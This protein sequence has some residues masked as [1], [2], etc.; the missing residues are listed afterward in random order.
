[1]VMDGQDWETIVAT[2][3]NRRSSL[4]DLVV[5]WQRSGYAESNFENW[6]KAELRVG[7]IAPP[8][9]ESARERLR[10]RCMQ[11]AFRRTKSNETT[12]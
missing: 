10:Q 1:M 12:S 6:A 2:S 3:I 11:L 9:V 8:C 7:A 5:A 4:L